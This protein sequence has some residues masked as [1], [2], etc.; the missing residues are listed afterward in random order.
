M[1]RKLEGLIIQYI[2]VILTWHLHAHPAAL[3]GLPL[4]GNLQ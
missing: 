4:S 3:N 2:T 1:E